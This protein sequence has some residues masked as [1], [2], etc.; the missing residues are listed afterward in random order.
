MND[1]EHIIRSEHGASVL[2]VTVAL[3]LFATVL[4]PAVT[5]AIQIM[6]RGNAEEDIKALILA[7]QVMEKTLQYRRY[8]DRSWQSKN[9]RWALQRNVDR[10]AP[11]VTVTI[12][13]WQA[14]GADKATGDKARGA[15]IV[16]LTTTRLSSHSAEE[17][18]PWKDPP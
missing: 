17:R 15:P 1:G 4:V 18:F 2:E 12:C 10:N 9:G 13:V 14:R 6:M 5:G 3:A 16:E 7:Q 11:L 8:D